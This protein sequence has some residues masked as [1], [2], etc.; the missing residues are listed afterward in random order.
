MVKVPKSR[1]RETARVIVLQWFN[2]V[3]CIF[4]EDTRAMRT[5]VA[6]SLLPHLMVLSLSGIRERTISSIP[7]HRSPGNRYHKMT[8]IAQAFNNQ[9]LSSVFVDCTIATL[10]IYEHLITLGEEVRVIWCRKFTG[11]TLL[12]LVNRY[13][14]LLIAVLVL[15]SLVFVDE[16]YFPTLRTYAIADRNRLL[17]TIPVFILTLVPIP[18]DIF[19]WTISIDFYRRKPLLCI[20]LVHIASKDLALVSELVSR[21]SLVFANLLMLTLV[22]R[23]TL[24]LYFQSRLSRITTPL[25][26]TLLQDGA[27]FFLTFLI[28]NLTTLLAEFIPALLVVAPA[29]S[30]LQE[31]IPILISRFMLNL[32]R[33]TESGNDTLP[34]STATSVGMT[35][36]SFRVPHSVIGNLGETFV[37]TRA[38]MEFSSEIFLGPDAVGD[39]RCRTPGK[40]LITYKKHTRLIC[41]PIFKVQYETTLFN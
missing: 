26:K 2:V 22:L 20:R 33:A 12:F 10:I 27:I 23:R 1:H 32:R 40:C 36:I 15:A 31:L 3:K 41:A 39:T 25:L 18:I 24:Y 28:L 11:A 16:S 4:D 30:L 38:D 6:N 37:E 29:G 9:V 21:G 17:W 5:C 13:L 7:P 34:G 8:T 19:Y 14:T 35:A